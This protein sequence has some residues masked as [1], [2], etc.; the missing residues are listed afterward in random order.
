MPRTL[1]L[2]VILIDPAVLSSARSRDPFDVLG[3][4]MLARGGRMLEQVVAAIQ[5]AT[6]PSGLTLD[7]AVVGG[8]LVRTAKLTRGIFDATQADESEAHGVLSRCVAETAITLCWLVE[9]GDEMTLARFRADSF[10]YWRQQIE[11]MRSDVEDDVGRA[12][13]EN[14]KR[15]VEGELRAAGLSWA[16]VPKRTNSW[17]PSMRQRC[18]ALGKGWIYDALFASHSSYVHPSWHELRT[19]HLG[20]E[21]EGV[22]LD[23]TYGGIA[24]VVAYVVTQLAAEACEAALSFLPHDL[25]PDDTAERIAHTVR[26]SRILATEFAGFGARGG[27]DE[28]L[29]RHHM[30]PEPG[31][32]SA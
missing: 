28:D 26:A 27:L 2:P 25:E 1:D 8:L 9:H 14:L 12:T 3:H 18:E 5:R 19:F 22:Q 31:A 23:A 30:H 15:H 32:R 11:E 6:P 29:S 20:T 17:G 10:A 13:R 21:A 7:E 4:Q 16:D 24:P